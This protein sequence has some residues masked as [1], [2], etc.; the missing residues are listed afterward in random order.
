MKIEKQY[1]AL[2][3]DGIWLN[4][5]TVP[6]YIKNLD[7]KTT[8]GV[9]LTAMG[10]TEDGKKE[11]IGFRFAYSESTANW[12]GLLLNFIQRGLKVPKIIVR[13]DCP[14]LKAAIDLSFPYVKYI[15]LYC[16]F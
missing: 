2:I 4:L 1:F 12:E 11:I 16:W 13:D 10:I 5:R 8:K 7:K 3:L 15:P 9:I 6:K 14:D